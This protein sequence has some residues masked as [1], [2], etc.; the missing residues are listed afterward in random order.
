MKSPKVSKSIS[1]ERRVPEAGTPEYTRWRANVV[2]GRRKSKA[3]RL[4][5]GLLTVRETARKYGLPPSFLGR[6]ADRGEIAVVEAGPRRYIHEA[7][8]ARKFGGGQ[9]AA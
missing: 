6:L 3:R 8:A 7:E 2:A 1:R 4:K 5:S 9:N